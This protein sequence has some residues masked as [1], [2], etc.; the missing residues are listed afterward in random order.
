MQ[1]GKLLKFT[2]PRGVDV[3]PLHVVTVAPGPIFVIVGTHTFI[4][5][6]SPV[7]MYKL[8][9]DFINTDIVVAGLEHPLAFAVTVIFPELKPTT[10]LIMFVLLVPVQVFGKVQV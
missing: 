6:S 10:E 2:L 4:V 3:V 9:N 8:S 5:L 1:L 7:L